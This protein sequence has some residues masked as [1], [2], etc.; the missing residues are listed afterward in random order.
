MSF[1]AIGVPIFVSRAAM[2]FVV[3]FSTVRRR[4][5][6]EASSIGF[7][8]SRTL[9]IASWLIARP[10]ASNDPQ[11]CSNTGTRRTFASFAA[12]QR[13]SPSTITSAPLS[14]LRTISGT[15]TPRSL[16]D[17]ASTFRS[18][19]LNVLRGWSGSGCSAPSATSASWPTFS[20]TAAIR[21]S[22]RPA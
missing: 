1:A 11:S 10:A 4:C 14:P 5:T 17:A 8:G 15:R 6:S 2:S 18:S 16:I 12:R 19:S 7:S 20:F 13:R 3:S 21:P 9:L 22:P